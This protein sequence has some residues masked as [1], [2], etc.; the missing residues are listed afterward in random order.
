LFFGNFG[1]IP[2]AGS[3]GFLL[4]FIEFKLFFVDVKDASSAYPVAL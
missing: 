2:K 4:F 1:L 3:V